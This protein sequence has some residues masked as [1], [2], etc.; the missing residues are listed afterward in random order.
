LCN[1]A[2]I[3]AGV[4]LQ[5]IIQFI[6]QLMGNIRVAVIEDQLQTRQMLSILI[7]GN[8]GYECVAAFNSAED[9]VANLPQL[10]VNVALMDIHMPGGM[11]GIECVRTLKSVCPSVEFIMCTSLEDSDNIYNALQAGATG[12]ITKST[13][14]EKILEAIADAY[15]GGSPMSSQIARKVIGYFFTAKPLKGNV[16][17]EK[18]SVREQEILHYLSKGYRYKEIA[19]MLFVSVETIRKHIHNIYEKLHVNSRTD[20]LNKVF[21]GK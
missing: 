2:G 8:E 6:N 15:N 14:P 4:F 9:A 18:L 20:A 16:E 1:C 7:N 11:T 21:S 19:T 12:Y 17:L 10:N 5:T 3:I 13:P